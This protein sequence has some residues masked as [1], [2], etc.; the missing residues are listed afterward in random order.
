MFRPA[1][2]RGG[3]VKCWV[4]AG[5]K[6]YGVCCRMMLTLVAAVLSGNV[7]AGNDAVPFRKLTIS[8]GL[9]SHEITCIYQDSRGFI[10]IGTD[11]GLNRFDGYQIQIYRNDHSNG[12]TIGGNTVRCL[13]EDRNNN[14]WIGFKGEGMSRLNLITGAVRNFVHDADDNGSISCDDISGSFMRHSEFDNLR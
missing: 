13:F 1:M 5:L 10:W 3:M 4:M 12:N 11:N 9:S 14:L 6:Y 2:F 8:E 7:W